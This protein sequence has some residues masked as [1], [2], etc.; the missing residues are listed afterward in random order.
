[1][2]TQADVVSEKAQEV[3]TLLLLV[4]AGRTGAPWG[5]VGG[6]VVHIVGSHRAPCQR[7]GTRQKDKD[8]APSYRIRTQPCMTVQ[9]LK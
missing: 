4:S 5:H 6:G 7:R 2:L 1:M 9:A 8:I 3:H